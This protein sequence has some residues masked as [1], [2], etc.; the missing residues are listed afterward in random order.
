ML[1]RYASYAGL[2]TAGTSTA[3]DKFSD[4]A[5]ISSYA[6]QAM[7]WACGSG[8]LDGYGDGTLKPNGLLTRAEL[9]TVLMQ[10]HELLLSQG[11]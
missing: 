2:N 4:K 8:L 11:A 5:E 6:V 1:Y 10:F 7:T 9:A 3:L